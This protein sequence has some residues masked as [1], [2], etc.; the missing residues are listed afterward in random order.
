MKTK[1]LKLRAIEL[2]ATEILSREQLKNVIGGSGG[3]GQICSGDAGCPPY[4]CRCVSQGPI[5]PNRCVC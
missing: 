4:P 2:G 5:G 3:G 1:K